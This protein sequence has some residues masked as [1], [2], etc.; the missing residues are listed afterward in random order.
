MALDSPI[1]EFVPLQIDIGEEFFAENF[2]LLGLQRFQCF[3]R[4]LSMQDRKM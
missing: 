2:Q 3:L 4:F 1:A